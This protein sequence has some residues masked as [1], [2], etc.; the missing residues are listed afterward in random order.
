MLPLITRRLIIRDHQPEDAVAMNQLLSNP[1]A[2]RYLPDL[3]TEGMEGTEENLR[4]ALAENVRTDRRMWFF[5]IIW[6]GDGTG[7]AP[8]LRN[9][10]D[11]LRGV[12]SSS[13]SYDSESGEY[14]GEIG[15][16]LTDITAEGSVAHF[17][18]FILPKWQG[19]GIVT[20]AAREVLRFAFKEGGALKAETGCLAENRSSEAVMQKLGMIREALLLKHTAHEGVLK[21]RVEYRLLREEWEATQHQDEEGTSEASVAVQHMPS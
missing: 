1:V 9:N 13:A 15:Y 19:R 11:D 20:E 17:G 21:D 6:R 18:W 2:M 10:A 8:L 12:D 16:T 5:A 7:G 3:R 4:Q 14:I